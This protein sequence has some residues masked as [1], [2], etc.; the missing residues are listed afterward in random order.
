MSRALVTGGA[1]FIGRHLVQAL[2]DRGLDVLVLDNLSW[3]SREALLQIRGVELVEGDAADLPQVLGRHG[4]F[5]HVFHLAALISA[6]ESL[7]KP[8]DYLKA[9]VTGLLRLIDFCR[10]LASPRLVFASTSGVYGNTTAATKRELDV[11][12]PATVYAATKLTGEHLLHMYRERVG[13]DDVSLRFFNVYGPGQSPKHPYANVTCRFSR[14]AALGAGVELFGD[15]Q[16]T[17]DFVYV[18]D[19]VDAI[20]AVA[21]GPVK[22][23]VYNVGTGQDVAIASLL[24]RVQRLGGRSIG[25]ERHAAWRNDIRHIRADISAITADHGFAPRVTLDEGLA[26][27]IEFFKRVGDAY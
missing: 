8:D 27:T 25:V 13:Y 26:S 7:E 19:V 12:A 9:N 17:R 20:L 5:T 2:I 22:G 15:G 1:G 4:S 16:Q 14:A 23:R 6:Y 24:E 11:P 18:S 21:F 10:S 3:G